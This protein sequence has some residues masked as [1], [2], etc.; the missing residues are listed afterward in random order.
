[1]PVQKEIPFSVQCPCLHQRLNRHGR[2]PASTKLS[3][4]ILSAIA[5]FEYRRLR[6]LQ[7]NEYQNKATIMIRIRIPNSVLP[8]YCWLTAVDLA[9]PS[10]S[11]S[12]RTS[13]DSPESESM[14]G[15]EKPMN[16][17]SHQSRRGRFLSG[18]G[19]LKWPCLFAAQIAVLWILFRQSRCPLEPGH[20]VNKIAPKCKLVF[21]FFWIFLE[22]TRRVR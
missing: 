8:S 15:V 19:R 11:S 14:L 22:S 17:S 2:P 16:I 7:S 9:M 5:R 10:S 12:P 6:P 13:S 4:I 18:L 3:G 20:D 21:E 1:L